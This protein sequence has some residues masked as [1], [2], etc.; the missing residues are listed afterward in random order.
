MFEEFEDEIIEWNKTALPDNT[1]D[2]QIAK[3]NEEH[4]E[5]IEAKKLNDTNKMLEECAD[6]IIAIIGV[7]RFSM[8]GYAIMSLLFKQ[9]PFQEESINVAIRKKLDILKTRKYEIVGNVYR[10]VEE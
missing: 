7:K 5:F 10:H 1:E 4:L 8:R 9:L 3:I 6:T 2:M